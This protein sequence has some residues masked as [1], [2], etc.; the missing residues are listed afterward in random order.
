MSDRLKALRERRGTIVATMSGILAKADQEK[1]D[2]TE[3]EAAKHSE[4]FD[5]QQIDL[6]LS[7]RMGSLSRSFYVGATNTAHVAYDDLADL[8]ERERRT[9]PAAQ[10]ARPIEN[11]L[12]LE[13]GGLVVHL[14]HGIGIYRGL[15]TIEGPD[16]LGEFLKIEFA[17]GTVAIG[18]V[19]FIFE[20]VLAIGMSKCD[21]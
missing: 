19:I 7:F 3:E 2:L 18:A 12:E 17:E 11:F 1:R 20:G 16:G 4:L 21:L 6:A 15:D 5:E 8:P 14:T 13:E 10:K 9:R